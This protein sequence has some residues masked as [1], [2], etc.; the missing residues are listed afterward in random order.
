MA[1]PNAPRDCLRLTHRGTISNLARFELSDGSETVD[2]DAFRPLVLREAISNYH[3][4]V[5]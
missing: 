2:L 3:L 1:S 5:V 4:T